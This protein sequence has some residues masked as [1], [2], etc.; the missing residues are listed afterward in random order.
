M[1]F[2]SMLLDDDDDDAEFGNLVGDVAVNGNQQQWWQVAGDEPRLHSYIVFVLSNLVS[3]KCKDSWLGG[4]SL[5]KA[6]S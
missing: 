4:S 1:F 5:F 6:V 3:F 2:S